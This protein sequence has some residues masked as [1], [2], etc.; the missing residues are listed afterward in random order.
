MRNSPPQSSA[1]RRPDIAETDNT[2]G[3]ADRFTAHVVVA[4]RERAG[5]WHGQPRGLA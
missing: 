5:R 2:D 3:A 4:V 1:I